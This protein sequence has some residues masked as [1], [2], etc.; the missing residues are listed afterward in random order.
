M[1]RNIELSVT[2]SWYGASDGCLL[3]LSPRQFNA[4]LMLDSNYF[5]IRNLGENQMN[6]NQNTNRLVT[7]VLCCILTAVPF[8]CVKY[9]PITDLPQHAS[10]I[11]LLLETLQ[12]P[13]GSP[14]KIQWFTPYSL[15]YLIL[16]ATWI[17]S[18]AENAGRIA[19]M[20][21]GMIWVISI[22][23]FAF[24]TGRPAAAA[25]IASL[26]FFNHTVYWGFYSFAIGFPV[27]L[28]WF[29]FISERRYDG[30]SIKEAAVIISLGML[31]YSSHILWLFAAVA[32]MIL[33]EA[34]FRSSRSALLRRILY[35]VPVF[36]VVIFWYPLLSG[37]SMATPPEWKRY[38]I[39]RI[40][41]GWMVDASLGGIQGPVEYMVFSFVILWLGACFI[42][43]R[44]KL[45]STVNF[46]MVLAGLMFLVSAYVLPD[47]YMNTIRFGHRWAP[48][49]MVMLILS[50]PPVPLRRVF[51]EI[52]ALVVL[53]SF[54]AVVAISWTA[55]EREELSG[56]SKS[57]AALNDKP[58]VL[59]LSSIMT[60]K[61]IKGFPFIQTFA[62]SQMLK[63]GTLNFSFAEFSPCLVVYKQ[64]FIRPWT[65][66]LE[67]FP[68][69]IKESDLKYFDSV[70]L[71]GGEDAHNK[72]AAM[73]HLTPVTHEGR[74]RLYAVRHD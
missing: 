60:G 3:H 65:G 48:I 66:G 51:A 39:D 74:W 26:F 1:G 5:K 10:Q 31:L 41:S 52:C 38:P 6:E 29:L 8:L 43:N 53:G 50:A 70:L 20:L 73:L 14:Y 24:R 22:H 11:R 62:Y 69:R 59:G 9:P 2:F 68:G 40:L 7:A 33:H 71:N 21:I 36:V 34:V 72:I 18:G 17:A 54:C 58:N 25:V 55:F 30:F 13:E 16:G 64:P 28:M 46:P 49:A 35:L 23:F 15:S 56:L 44:G 19:M 61:Y 45:E 37:S 47:K 42:G 63:G 57:L 32:W 4:G 67:W 27:Y 12:D